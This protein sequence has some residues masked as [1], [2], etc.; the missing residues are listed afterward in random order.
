MAQRSDVLSPE[1][2]RTH[3]THHSKG[4]LAAQILEDVFALYTSPYTLKHVGSVGL[5][6]IGKET[7]IDPPIMHPRRRV[8]VMVIGNHSAGKSSFINWYIEEDVQPTSVAVETQGFTLV[9]SGTEAQDIRGKGAMIDNEHIRAAAT[10]MG[11]DGPRFIEN[12]S[13]VVRTSRA[14]D[15]ARIDLLDTPGLVDG[16]VTY[17]FDVN[18]SIVELATF[19]DLI[20]VFLDPIGQALCTRTMDVVKQLN[21]RGHHDKMRYFLTK[22]DTVARREDLSKVLVQVTTNLSLRVKNTHG[23]N[24]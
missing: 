22:A 15:F 12:L 24:V 2:S 23:F 17:P 4:A 14:K 3:G 6:A 18:R 20:L 7:S 1:T 13:L 10:R 21:D 8:T 11:G 16:N 9:R 19:A 5:E